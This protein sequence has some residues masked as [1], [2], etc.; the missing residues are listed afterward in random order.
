MRAL[1]DTCRL[2]RDHLT[3]ADCWAL[4]ALTAAEASQ[5][6]NR[7]ALEYPFVHYGRATCDGANGIGN[8]GPIDEMPSPHFTTEQVLDYF[9]RMF[10]FNADETVAI[11]GAHNLGRLNNDNSGFDGPW[12]R[13]RFSLTNEFYRLLIDRDDRTLA[14]PNY[15]SRNNG[16]DNDQFLW[17]RR[18]RDRR[19]RR[20]MLNADMSLVSDFSG[21]IDVNTGEVA[22][23][24]IRSDVRNGGLPECPRAS[25]TFDKVSQF[26]RDNRSFLREFR[27]ALTKM[28][29]NEQDLSVCDGQ[30]GPLCDLSA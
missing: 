19:R 23:C 11:M 21:H 27:N 14:T 25:A 1:R 6:D 22:T 17:L 16:N 28:M 7:D 13:S 30:T 15:R 20:I 9:D 12:V 3:R 29:L 8:G 26:S 18:S 2:Y 24:V 10:D 4:A 5:P